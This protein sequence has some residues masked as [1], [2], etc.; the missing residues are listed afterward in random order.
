MARKPKEQDNVMIPWDG[1]QAYLR[2]RGDR[3][4]MDI[5]PHDGERIRRGTKKSTLPE[6][7]RVIRALLGQL[8][9]GE[10][11]P[12]AESYT[13]GDML[14]EYLETKRAEGEWDDK[15]YY[16][17]VLYTNSHFGPFL[18]HMRPAEVTTQ[19]IQN[20]RTKR[21]NDYGRQ[22]SNRKPDGEARR[23]SVKAAP[24][25][26][27]PTT[28]NRELAFLKGAFRWKHNLNKLVIPTLP[29]FLIS[30]MKRRREG[31]IAYPEFLDR[32]LPKLPFHIKALS[33]L[34]L[35]WGG[36]R[37]EWLKLDWSDINFENMVIHFDHTKS[38]HPRE[39]RIV[40]GLMLQLLSELKMYHDRQ[41][42]K[43]PA[44]FTY[45]GRRLKEFKR[46]WR[47]ATRAAG[48]PGL[49]FHD[50]RRSAATF[51][52]DAGLTEEEIM[53]AM[54][55]ETNSM[56]RHYGIKGKAQLDS[57]ANKVTAHLGALGKAS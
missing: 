21:L 3:Y 4:H 23:P 16:G 29:D 48:Y 56:F 36:R 50:T 37:K 43:E 49:L 55:H 28:V 15:V 24:R 44:V 14:R 38:K 54:G 30:N 42:P 5:T 19:V 20:Y 12:P 34:A 9:R 47:T 1:G 18:G 2:R 11:Q 57:S 8:T 39:V 7:D 17:Y 25:S 33:Y 53:Q 27:S 51:L 35:V 46:S 22:G 10:Y 26:I 41:H 40:P 45:E 52:R 13:V 31:F 32:L 6:A